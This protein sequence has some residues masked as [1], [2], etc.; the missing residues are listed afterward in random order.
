MNTFILLN[1]SEYLNI[2]HTKLRH[3]CI[4]N[5]DQYRKTLLPFQIVYMVIWLISIVS[6]FSSKGTPKQGIVFFNDLFR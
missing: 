2:I 6:S 1:W 5:N 3:S 4:L